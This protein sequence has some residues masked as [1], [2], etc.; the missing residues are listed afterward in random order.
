[1]LIDN[2]F[3]EIFFGAFFIWYLR[4]IWSVIRG[5]RAATKEMMHTFCGGSKKYYAP[6]PPNPAHMA[7]AQTTKDIDTSRLNALFMNPN[8]SSP[9]GNVSYDVNSQNIGGQNIQRPT[10]T[11][12]LSEPEKRQMEMR[13]KLSEHLNSAGMNLAQQMPQNPLSGQGFTQ[14][15]GVNLG[16]ISPVS[17][18]NDFGKER[19]NIENAIYKRQMRFLEP[20][21]KNREEQLRER[22]VQTGNPMGTPLH[23]KEMK[24]YENYRNEALADLANRATLGG[25]EEQNR[26]FNI[27]NM[28][29]GQQTEEA[30]R[31]YN[32]TN[33]QRQNEMSEAQMLRNQQIN[34]LAALLQGREAITQPQGAGY[35]Q[36]GMRSPD[37]MG[38][39]QNNYAQQAQN[40]NNMFHNQQA[41]R[42]GMMSGLFSLGGSVLGGPFGGMI[43]RGVGSLFGGH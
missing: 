5:G 37:I 2:Y 16:G 43:G 40:Y 24:N 7:Q 26:L 36:L 35:N 23:S 32:V 31:P 14:R 25:S 6:T 11:I 22:L 3:Y 28:L 9:Y 13:N 4:C 17:N 20:E 39:M 1:M 15:A 21:L 33:Q 27:A 29:R 30:M 34:E 10:Q 12:N 19:E 38:A 42:N 41:N 18:L 8:I